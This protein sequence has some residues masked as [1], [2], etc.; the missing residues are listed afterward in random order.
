MS[1]EID[2]IEREIMQ[3]EMERQALKK[4]KDAA[5]KERLK[6]LER[7]L[8]WA[9]SLSS[10]F[11]R[12]LLAASFSF[13]SACRS[14]SCCMISRSIKSIS[15]DIESSYIFKRERASSYRSNSLSCRI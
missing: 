15:V 10:F 7:E 9:N 1:T 14:I 8:A 5:S 13:L 6:K 12:S 2:L 4:E 11:K 3:H